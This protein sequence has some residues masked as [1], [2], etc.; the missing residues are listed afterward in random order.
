[1]YVLCVFVFM[2]R[3]CK[4]YHKKTKSPTANI[5]VFLNNLTVIS[6][7]HCKP[8][9]RLVGVIC[10]RLN[11]G[12]VLWHQVK[13]ERLLFDLYAKSHLDKGLMAG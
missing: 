8:S 1:M 2:I 10:S 11:C 6:Q 4:W 13:T 7:F 5:N 3:T 9:S 12:C